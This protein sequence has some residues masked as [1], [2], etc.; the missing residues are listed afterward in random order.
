MT[1]VRRPRVLAVVRRFKWQHIDLL[2]ALGREVDLRVAW[3]EEGHEGSVERARRAGLELDDL[4]L[5]RDPDERD[6][7]AALAAAVER[8]QPDLV[9][10]L[11]YRHEA[12]T[13]RLRALLGATTPLVFECRDPATTLLSARPGDG[14]WRTEAAALAAA[15]AWIVVSDALRAYYERAHGI[16]ARDVVVVPHAFAAATAGP[17]M[18]KLSAEDGRLHLA[19]VGTASEDPTRSRWYPGIIRA[20]VAQGVVVHS[21]FHASSPEVV[22]TYE[23]LSAELPD[24]HAHPT[25]PFRVG[26]LLSDLTSRYDVMGVFHQLDAPRNEAA[27]LAVCLPTKAVSGWFHG[28]IPVV[29]T[30]HYRG[31]TERIDRWGIGFIA[32][33]ADALPTAV[34]DRDAVAAATAA[35]L[36]VRDEFSQETVAGRIAALYRTLLARGG[37]WG[38]GVTSGAS[39]S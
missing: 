39:G 6:L 2:L 26:T 10:V 36:A 9:H 37:P 7:D 22:A 25:V 20:L 19:L 17:P 13:L 34:F 8:A 12:L 1:V 23:R 28:A 38:T 3:S 21:H 11:Y 24:Y 30:A 4:G 29:T 32:A 33:S 27:T 16:V 14:V 5:P 31:I 18:P 35:C 15:D